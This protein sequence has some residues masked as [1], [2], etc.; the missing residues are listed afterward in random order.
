MH[1]I[2]NLL[3]AT[4]SVFEEPFYRSVILVCSHDEKH[5]MGLVI[6]KNYDNFDFKSLCNEIKIDPQK[7]KNK[8]VL[9]GGPIE[10]NRG[11]VLHTS[12][13]INSETLFIDNNFALTSNSK[14]LKDIALDTG[15]KQSLV[16]MG[17][18]GWH[19]GQLEMEI[20][21]NSWLTL[22]ATKE[23]VFCPDIKSI[24]INSLNKLGIDHKKFSS[25][26]GHA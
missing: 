20:K 11:F 14:I 21:N 22:P 2:G 17:Y 8:N 23:I 1:L 7:S 3:I 15:P 25:D 26:Y 13:K 9:I 16:I 10:L 18:S 19:S 12:E 4:P 5:T 24:W 6:N